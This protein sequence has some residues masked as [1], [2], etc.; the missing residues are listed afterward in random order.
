MELRKLALFLVGVHTTNGKWVDSKAKPLVLLAER[1]DCF[2]VAGVDGRE[3]ARKN[4]LAH[5]FRLAAEHIQ[6]SSRQD[7]FDSSVVEVAHDDVQR[8]VESL[9]YIMAQS[10]A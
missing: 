10:A 4:R 5:A 2:L 7:L 3:G 8:F 1:R 9:H 6:T